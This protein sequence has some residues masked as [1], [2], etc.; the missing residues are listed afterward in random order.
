ML[1]DEF[2]SR[3]SWVRNDSRGE[4]ECQLSWQYLD[5]ND[6]LRAVIY[7]LEGRISLYLFEHQINDEYVEREGAKLALKQRYGEAFH[8][9]LKLR[10]SLA[11]GNKATQYGKK[12]H[13]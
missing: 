5:R 11:H 10:N 3:L 13:H 12:R 8:Q 7:G 1:A 9:L 4:R 6:F 2:Q